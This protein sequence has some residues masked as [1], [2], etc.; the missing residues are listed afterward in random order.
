MTADDLRLITQLTSDVIEAELPVH[1][2]DLPLNEALSI[3][4]IAFLPDEV[5]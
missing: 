2:T 4:G 1:C 5:T 3:P